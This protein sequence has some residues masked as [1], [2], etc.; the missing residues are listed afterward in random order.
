M[1]VVQP[2]TPG[3]PYTEQLYMVQFNKLIAFITVTFVIAVSTR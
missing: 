1:E 3:E 2:A